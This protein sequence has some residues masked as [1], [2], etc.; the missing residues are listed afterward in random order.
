MEVWR[1]GGVEEWWSSHLY[2][3]VP[4]PSTTTSPQAPH[5]SHTSAGRPGRTVL[6]VTRGEKERHRG[7]LG[8]VDS[9]S[10]AAEVSEESEV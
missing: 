3:A 2:W 7:R 6:E 9:C 1:C 4:S 8:G 10:S 5:S